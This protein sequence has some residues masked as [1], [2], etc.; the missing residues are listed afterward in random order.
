MNIHEYQAKA[1][2]Q[3]FGIVIPPGKVATSP[4]EAA[5]I[6]ESLPATDFMVK[7]QVHAGGRNDAGG[8]RKASSPRAAR[9]AAAELLGKTLVTDQT[10]TRGSKV[11]KVYVEAM[12]EVASELYLA[13]YADAASG[14][15]ALL[16]S[17]HGGADFEQRADAEP[18]NVKIA[19]LP[20]VDLPP[21]EAIATLLDQLGLE[22]DLQSQL[23]GLCKKLIK[24][25][26]GLDALLVEI[27]PLG[28]TS[29]GGLLALD[30]KVVLDDNA[31]SRHPELE[32]LRDVNE[33][34][35]VEFQA[36]RHEVNY[37]QMDGNI[38][39]VVNGAG[40]AL[41]TLDMLRD[42]G[43]QPANFMDIRT[44]A[45]SLDI[46]RGIDLMFSDPRVKAVLV[47]VHAGGTTRCDTI[48][49]AIGISRGR[50]GCSIPIVYRAAGNMDGFSRTILKNC[51]INFT[52]ADNMA[53][54]V[55]KVVA[56]SG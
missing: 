20:S 52:E 4:D 50:V 31:L 11:S 49:E 9:S 37:V 3:K 40:L 56:L 32:A 22:E 51:G 53:D 33:L 25:F 43:G 47:N 17:R 23:E 55:N 6:A 2:L 45:T 13:V 41:A 16:G 15:I 48:A 7:A 1:L 27:N 35:P 5:Q 38:G 34:D 44:T 8:V 28:V 19:L 30:A 10:G 36:Q 46:A 12:A 26:I 24:A 18:D 54:A 42:A 39:V 14:Q 21:D 29:Q